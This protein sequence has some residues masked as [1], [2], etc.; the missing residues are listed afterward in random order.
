MMTKI[1]LSDR[2]RRIRDKHALSERFLAKSL[3][4]AFCVGKELISAKKA[5]GHGEWIDFI[6]KNFSFSVRTA[7]AYMRL[8]RHKEELQEKFGTSWG[9]RTV[10]QAL[11][12]MASDREDDQDAPPGVNG[13]N[14]DDATPKAPPATEPQDEHDSYG[15]KLGKKPSAI[16]KN[17]SEYSEKADRTEQPRPQPETGNKTNQSPLRPPF[18][19][20]P[21]ERVSVSIPEVVSAMVE[22]GRARCTQQIT[23]LE[24]RMKWNGADGDTKAR[25]DWWHAIREMVP[26]LAKRIQ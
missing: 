19:I 25:R 12:I 17:G 4:E 7:Q 22:G 5:V 8:A 6:V 21:V 24:N 15:K 1:S 3:R 13:V 18:P 26:E 16:A 23:E 11:A 10:S 14:Q 20:S 2:V 9:D